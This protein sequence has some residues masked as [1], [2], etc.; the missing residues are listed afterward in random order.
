[1]FGEQFVTGYSVMFVLGIGVLARAAVGPGERFLSMLGQQKL[2]ALT[3]FVAVLTNLSLCF[4]LIPSHG[5]L[6]AAIATSAAFIVES[7]MIFIIAK[8]RLGFHLFVFGGA[9]T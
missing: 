3:A 7:A 6:G 1:L 8:R 9:R 2:C 5:I 4:I